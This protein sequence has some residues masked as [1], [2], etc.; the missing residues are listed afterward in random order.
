[1]DIICHY[2]IFFG[3][4]AIISRHYTAWFDHA[5]TKEPWSSGGDSCSKGHEFESQYPI[6][7]VHFFTYLFVVKFVMCVWKDKNKWKRGRGSHIFLKKNRTK[8]KHNCSTFAYLLPFRGRYSCQ[9][10]SEKI[11]QNNLWSCRCSSA[12]CTSGG[13]C[14]AAT[15]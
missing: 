11:Y 12:G 5:Y 14:C 2:F 9:W 15:S 3:H 1:M 13:G 8:R 10:T 6:L 7:D 4:L